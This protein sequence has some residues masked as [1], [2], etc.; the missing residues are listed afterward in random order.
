MSTSNLQVEVGPEK[1]HPRIGTT[2]HENFKVTLV[3][4]PSCSVSAYSADSRLASRTKDDGAR[5]ILSR[6]SQAACHGHAPV[7]LWTCRP[8]SRWRLKS[9]ATPSASTTMRSRKSAAL[10]ALRF[11][12][13][14]GGRRLVLETGSRLAS[15]G[16]RR[17]CPGRIG[18]LADLQESA[19][20]CPTSGTTIACRPAPGSIPCWCTPSP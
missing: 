16:D 3:E 2:P 5:A 12:R 10:C 17:I 20:P 6:R 9:R 14:A 11:C 8:S 19:V 13:G 15:G 18:G 1:F 7:V 4:T